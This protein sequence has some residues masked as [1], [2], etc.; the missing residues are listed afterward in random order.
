MEDKLVKY[1]WENVQSNINEKIDSESDD[2]TTETIKLAFEKKRSDDR[3]KW[4]L[5]YNK[6][7]VLDNNDKSVPIPNFIHKELKHFS[8]DD[9]NR[10]IPSICDGLKIS[11][12]KILYSTFLRK[13]FTK[14]DEL[15]GAQLA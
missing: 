12:R 3:K 5:N 1:T 8:N 7:E 11:T 6:D 14:K 9:L 13:L 2:E 4:L 15:R 10:S